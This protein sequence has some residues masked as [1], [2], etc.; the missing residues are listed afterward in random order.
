MAAGGGNYTL[1][2]E[3]QLIDNITATTER[4]EGRLKSLED[5]QDR[6]RSST[7]SQNISFIA[8]VTAVSSVHRG[9]TRATS[10]MREL[11]LISE[12]DAQAMVKFNAAVGLVAGTFQLLK[13]AVQII[14]MVRGAEVALAGV[15]TYRAVLRNPASVALIGVG[16]AAAGGA[17]GYMMGT[18]QGNITNNELNVNYGGAGDQGTKR[19]MARDLFEMMGG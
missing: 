10:S 9:L 14:N 11:G 13:G 19:G 17:V 2:Y 1:S 12:K 7:D 15:E 3:L 6:S 5:Q 16:L 4:M 8:Q 18:S